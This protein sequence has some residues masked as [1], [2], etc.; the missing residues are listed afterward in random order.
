[1][2]HRV[3][4]Q[5]LQRVFVF[6]L[7]ICGLV[8][9]LQLGGVNGLSQG[10]AVKSKSRAAAQRGAQK[11]YE[12]GQALDLT[13]LQCSGEI[14]FPS[15]GISADRLEISGGNV[16]LTSGGIVVKRGE[17]IAYAQ[18]KYFVDSNV[19]F[20]FDRSDKPFRSSE[21]KPPVIISLNLVQ[22]RTNPRRLALISI[23]IGDSPVTRIALSCASAEAS[24]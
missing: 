20:I 22:D 11:K 2:E 5:S 12:V 16:A 23:P 21:W 7:P 9:G 14:S 13:L 18:S 1:M 3:I 17:V 6:L 15:A 4:R 8:L 24:R 19:A 10:G